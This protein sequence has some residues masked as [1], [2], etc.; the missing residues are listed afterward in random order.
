MAQEQSCDEDLSPKAVKLYEKG[1]DKKT[2]KYKRVGYLKDALEIEPDYIAA[3]FAIA[4][5]KIKTAKYE[6][7]SFKPAEEHLL[8]VAINCPNFHSDVFY[9]LAEI[10]LGRKEY[11]QAVS[12]QK[13]FLKRKYHEYANGWCSSTCFFSSRS[14][15]QYRISW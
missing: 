2:D 6:G 5:E 8:K 11:A 14:R 9:Y 10:V 1:T 7:N 15:W 12:Y 13:Q 3:N 4:I